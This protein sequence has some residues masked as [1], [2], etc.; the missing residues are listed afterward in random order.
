MSD[1]ACS[2]CEENFNCK[3][4]DFSYDCYKKSIRNIRDHLSKEDLIYLNDMLVVIERMLE[5]TDDD[6]FRNIINGTKAVLDLYDGK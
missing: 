6:N 3:Y 5:E 1:S 4:Y 2:N